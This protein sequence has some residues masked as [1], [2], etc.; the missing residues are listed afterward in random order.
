M[1]KPQEC[2]DAA[3]RPK[4]H[5]DGGRARTLQLFKNWSVLGP[6]MIYF[7]LLKADF[8][9]GLQNGPALAQ[10]QQAIMISSIGP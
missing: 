4:K 3:P 1:I 10:I 8:I 7:F 9:R 2:Q 6:E 5:Q